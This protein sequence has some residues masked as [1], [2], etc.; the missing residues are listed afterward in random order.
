MEIRQLLLKV[1]KLKAKDLGFDA[2]ELEGVADNLAGNLTISDEATEEETNAIID[3]A[4]AAIVPI[5]KLGQSQA[6]RVVDKWKKDHPE[7]KPAAPEPADPTP[8]PAPEPPKPQE[9]TNPQADM[10]KEFQKQLKE[11]Q[12]RFNNS[13]REMR[14]KSSSLQKEI[15]AMVV[16]RQKANRKATLDEILKDAGTFGERIM[17][18]YNRMT[19]ETEE[20]FNDYVEEVKKDKEAY[21]QELADAGLANHTTA[22]NGNPI[23]APEVLTDEQVIALAKGEN[24]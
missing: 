9:P 7:P 2:K 19:F 12:E 8:N 20:A 13:L 15:D 18:N 21:K 5:L 22:P 16:E 1:L 10:L 23:V 6:N 24:L 11:E 4:V 14:E 3:K 17:R